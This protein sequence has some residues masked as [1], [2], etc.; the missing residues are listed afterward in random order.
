MIL[1]RPRGAHQEANLRLRGLPALA[2]VRVGAAVRPHITAAVRPTPSAAALPAADALGSLGA[3]S[4]GCPSTAMPPARVR[5]VEVLVVASPTPHASPGRWPRVPG[6]CFAASLLAICT[7][8]LGPKPATGVHELEAAYTAVGLPTAGDGQ[9]SKRGV[10]ARAICTPGL[11]STAVDGAVWKEQGALS[12]RTTA[13]VRV[14][15]IQRLAHPDHMACA[16]TPGLRSN[17]SWKLARPRPLASL[18]GSVTALA[19]TKSSRD[20]LPVPCG[21][22]AGPLC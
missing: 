2:A 10:L 11:E 3:S 16:S 19:C 7:I 14:T 21:V 5:V 6:Q 15:A 4:R 13:R 9:P 18:G 17:A 22:R 20:N 1:M 12:M 8:G